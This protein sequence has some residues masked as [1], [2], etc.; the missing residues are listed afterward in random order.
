[1]TLFRRNRV[2]ISILDLTFTVEEETVILALHPEHGGV[3]TMSLGDLHEDGRRITELF[4]RPKFQR[5]GV[6]TAMWEFAIREGLNPV[7][8]SDRSADGDAWA[9][10]VSP[11][12]DI[13]PNTWEE[14][15]E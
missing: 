9:M 4:V 12:S 10:S 7:H 8:S 11:L 13:P 14:D 15:D 5:Q 2:R 6:A 3:G 1:M